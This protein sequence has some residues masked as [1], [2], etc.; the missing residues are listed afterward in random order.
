MSTYAVVYPLGRRV[1]RATARAARPHTLDGA[2]I[3]ELSNHKFEAEFTFEVIE[4]ALLKRFPT[5]KFVS[6]ERF[7]DTYGAR[8]SEVIRD[9]P[10]KL[11]LYEC[12]VV[13]SG[14]AG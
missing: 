2:T 1:R 5:A 13:I 10:E 9:L 14:N 3:G 4:N 12:D 6:F 11:R 7:G 8:E